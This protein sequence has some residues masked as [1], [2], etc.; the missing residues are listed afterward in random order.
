MTLSREHSAATAP[1]GETG[2]IAA[3][4]QELAEVREHQAAMARVLRAISASPGDL[5]PIYE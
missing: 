2:E 1:A 5:A 4:R 3:L